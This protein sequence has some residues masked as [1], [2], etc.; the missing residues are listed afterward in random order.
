MLENRLSII[1]TGLEHSEHMRHAPPGITLGMVMPNSGA[2]SHNH[3]FTMSDRAKLRSRHVPDGLCV[4]CAECV[5]PGIRQTRHHPRVSSLGHE[6]SSSIDSDTMADHGRKLSCVGYLV[7][8]LVVIGLE[9]A[10]PGTRYP[11]THTG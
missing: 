6:S 8:H 5:I 4:A 3:R 7:V 9:R 1:G 2:A 11:T 10:I